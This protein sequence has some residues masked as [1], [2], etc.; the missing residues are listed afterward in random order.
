MLSKLIFRLFMLSFSVCITALIPASMTLATPK[1]TTFRIIDFRG[2][3]IPSVWHGLTSN[4]QFASHLWLLGKAKV[5]DKLLPQTRPPVSGTTPNSKC[6]FRQVAFHLA[7]A[8]LPQ[9]SCIGQYMEPQRFDC[10][11]CDDGI[12][13]QVFYSTGTEPHHGYNPSGIEQ[14]N[15]CEV[16]ERAC[17]NP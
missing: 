16:A 3:Q 4:V 5:Q 7:P 10:G 2:V 8:A 17:Y 1:A 6:V 11:S 12:Q 15:G 13:Y 14:C 9:G